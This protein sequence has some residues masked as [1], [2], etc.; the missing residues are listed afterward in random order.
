MKQGLKDPV[1]AEDEPLDR[2]C[3]YAHNIVDLRLTNK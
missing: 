1:G 2:V 3:F